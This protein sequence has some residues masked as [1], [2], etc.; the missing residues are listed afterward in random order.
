MQQ[1]DSDTG[2]AAEGPLQGIPGVVSSFPGVDALGRGCR[3]ASTVTVYRARRTAPGRGIRLG[4]GVQLFEGVRLVVGDLGENARADLWIGDR[5]I[6]NVYSYLSGEG[7]LYVG[8]KVL[9]GPHCR[10][11]SAGH[12]VDGEAPAIMDAGLTYGAVRVEDGAWLGAG[13]TVL[14]GVRVGK[15]AVIGAASVVTRDIPDFAVAVGAPAKVL[16]YR[17][18]FKPPAARARRPWWRRLRVQLPPLGAR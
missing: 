17:R 14:P 5:T 12:E 18:G 3:V 4:A 15:G 2:A 10:L 6:V 1:A 13:V 16:R 7:G 9:I 8:E 11:L